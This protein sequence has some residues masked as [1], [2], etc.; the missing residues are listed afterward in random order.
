MFLVPLCA[1]NQQKKKNTVRVYGTIRPI[2]VPVI[3]RITRNEV[4]ADNPTQWDYDINASKKQVR[5]QTF[6]QTVGEETILNFVA[7]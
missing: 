4:N 5:I 6:T 3:M 2:R 1:E 7:L